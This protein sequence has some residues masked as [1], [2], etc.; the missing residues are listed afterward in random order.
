MIEFFT[1]GSNGDFRCWQFDLFNPEHLYYLPYPVDAVPHLKETD[2]TCAVAIPEF[3]KK[4]DIMTDNNPEDALN[5]PFTVLIGTKDGSILMFDRDQNM[6][7]IEN[8][9]K[10]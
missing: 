2:F 6:P 5:K 4:K 10:V 8:G 1:V 3:Q 9:R 7:W